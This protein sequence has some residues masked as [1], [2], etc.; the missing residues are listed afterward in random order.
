MKK[1]YLTLTTLSLALL[2]SAC[3]GS[4]DNSETLITIPP[5]ETYEDIVAG[6]IVV[7]D[8]V[9]TSIKTVFNT[10]GSKKVCVLTGAAHIVR[11]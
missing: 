2:L 8:D 3:G 11:Q 10:D 9:N 7:Q 5:C 1:I 6:D 4:E